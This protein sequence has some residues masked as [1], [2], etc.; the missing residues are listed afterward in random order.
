MRHTIILFS[1]LI[2][3]TT[4]GQSSEDHLEPAQS[5]FNMYNH[6][7]DYYPF[8]YKH[9][10][11]DISDGQVISMLTMP[12]FTP[13]SLMCLENI[14]KEGKKYKVIY[15][16][17]T[18]SIWCKKNRNEIEV[19]RYEEEI[20][21][22]T[23]NLIK[24]VFKTALL[25]TKFKEQK[26]I[27]LDGVTYVVSGNFGLSGTFSGEVWSPNEGTKMYDLIEFGEA[28]ISLAKSDNNSD[29]LKFKATIK[30]KGGK[31]FKRL[32]GG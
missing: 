16:V 27:G 23:A 14:D 3:S 21:T 15:K 18:E 2:S 6:E 5:Y 17:C 26:D 9:L 20:D 24:K 28:I 7:K 4:F 25:Q 22:A 1:I 30:D 8:I 32:N 12:S 29:R 19:T 11:A 31:L 10:L 13:E